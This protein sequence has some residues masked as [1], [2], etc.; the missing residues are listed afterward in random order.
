M[1]TYLRG[2]RHKA[3]CILL[4]SVLSLRT[5]YTCR[6]ITL[7]PVRKTSG[8]YRPGEVEGESYWVREPIALCGTYEMNTVFTKNRRYYVSESAGR[9][10]IDFGLVVLETNPEPRS[11]RSG[12][13]SGLRRSSSTT[14]LTNT[15]LPIVID[16]G[17]QSQLENART[18]DLRE[19]Q[20]Q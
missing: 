18:T 5:N 11:T 14:T 13:C 4:P 16:E 17:L 1:K 20:Q 12:T 19:Q 2:G 7:L 9:C 3:P 15:V 8:T 6:H 10:C